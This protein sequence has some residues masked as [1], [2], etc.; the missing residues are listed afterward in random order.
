M[1]LNWQLLPSKLGSTQPCISWNPI[2]TSKSH[3]VHTMYVQIVMYWYPVYRQ[4]GG[5][6]CYL[7]STIVRV[8]V[9]LIRSDNSPTSE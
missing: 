8:S 1:G 6:L 4:L 9:M 7:K 5:N 2:S 3:I